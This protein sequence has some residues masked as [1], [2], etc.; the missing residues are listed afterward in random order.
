MGCVW[1]VPM[2]RLG[3]ASG[4]F[5]PLLGSVELAQGCPDARVEVPDLVPVR[6]NRLSFPEDQA[7]PYSRGR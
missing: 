5:F 4:G 2:A 7:F 6:K 1:T 3:I